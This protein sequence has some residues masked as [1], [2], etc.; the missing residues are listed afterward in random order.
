MIIK[1]LLFIIILIFTYETIQTLYKLREEYFS[2][3]H[4]QYIDYDYTG[5]DT[6]RDNFVNLSGNPEQDDIA[7]IIAINCKNPH[8][9]TYPYSKGL[10]MGY[11]PPDDE[12]LDKPEYS[13]FKPLE[14]DSNRKYYYRRDILIPEGYRRSS[15]D[16]KEIAKVP[17]W[18]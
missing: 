17:K 6:G 18:D 13:R 15:D 12:E 1:S 10:I 11:Q 14:Y 4:N 8:Y 3:K 7:K 5:R 9:L 16:D 2:Q